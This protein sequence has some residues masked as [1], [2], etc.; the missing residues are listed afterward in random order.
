MS[1][2]RRHVRGRGALVIA[3]SLGACSGEPEDKNARGAGLPAAD[4]PIGRRAS[5]YATGMR[6]MFD[7][8]PGLVLLL[9]PAL[10]PRSRTAEPEDSATSDLIQALRETRTIQGTCA[11]RRGTDRR[12][13]PICEASAAGYI[14]RVSDIFQASGDTVQLYVTAERYR[15]ARDTAGFQPPLRIEQRYDLT[16]R[17][18][19]WSVARKARLVK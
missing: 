15:A 5:A 1:T 7:V 2:I 4:L 8:G 6:G 14:I 17:G 18:D 11:P 10:L 19:A 13:A 12:S 3:L 9:D 16:P